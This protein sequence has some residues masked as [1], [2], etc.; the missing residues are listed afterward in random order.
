MQII[1]KKSELFK[2]IDDRPAINKYKFAVACGISKHIFAN[3]RRGIRDTELILNSEVLELY[4]YK[5]TN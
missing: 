3:G 4:G 2:F 1:L 5:N